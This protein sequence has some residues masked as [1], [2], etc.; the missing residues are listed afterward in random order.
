MHRLRHLRQGKTSA[1]MCKLVTLSCMDVVLGLQPAGWRA[2]RCA[3]SVASAPGHGCLP[4]L[5]C[6]RSC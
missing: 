5:Q 6:C 4:L 3:S 1:W 2:Q